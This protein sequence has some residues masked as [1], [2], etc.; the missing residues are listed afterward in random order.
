MPFLR[1]AK[2]AEDLSPD[3][4]WVKYSIDELLIMGRIF[5]YF[6]ILRPTSPL[7]TASS[8]KRANDEFLIA[9]HADSLRAVE[10]C[11]QHPAKM[12]K[13]VNNKLDP[14]M[15]RSDGGVDWFSSPTQS[16][17][18]IWVQ[19]AS[20]EFAHMRCLSEFNSITGRVIAPFKTVFPE[21]FDINRPEDVV[22]LQSLVDTSP[23]LLPVVKQPPF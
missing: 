18:E 9:T 22:A 13:I 12:W 17:P 2:F 5:D 21:G 11:K 1:P 3:I 16:L 8:I 10:L 6:S 7:R 23:N 14:L 15:Q 4:G 19:N 20:M